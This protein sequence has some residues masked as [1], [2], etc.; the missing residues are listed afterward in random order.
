MAGWKLR[1]DKTLT[2]TSDEETSPGDLM[3]PS[4]SIDGPLPSPPINHAQIEVEAEDEE[5]K[6]PHDSNA[7]PDILSTHTAV[8]VEDEPVTVEDI[9]HDTPSFAFVSDDFESPEPTFDT[10]EPT[11]KNSQ[12]SVLHF[13][14]PE[15]TPAAEV[16]SHLAAPQ[17]PIAVASPPQSAAPVAS[18]SFPAQPDPELSTATLRMDRSELMAGISA[19]SGYA[20]PSVS[21]F[22]LEVPKPVELE[23]PHTL[24]VSIGRLSATFEITKEVTV[25]G[26][27]DTELMYYPDIEIE[28]DD[29]V[30]RRHAEILRH[31]KDYYL[32]DAG[33]TNGTLLNGET[34]T[35]HEERLLAHGD[36]IHVGER[37]EIIF[38]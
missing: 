10:E 3:P 22:L 38:E 16:T 1:K 15:A 19:K 31:E 12:E 24:L 14:S 8:S 2:E 13:D 4:S 30:S 25:I 37:T 5:W 17:E 28:L 27:P 35:P 9:E 33:S 32:I 20:L 23:P 34:L 7:E 36:R 29:A 6:I 21:P 18:L 11:E 26:R